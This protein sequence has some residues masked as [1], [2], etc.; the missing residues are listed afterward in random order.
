[1]RV[2]FSSTSGL[3]HVQPMLPLALAAQ[4]QGHEVLWVSAPDA[5]PRVAAA[6]LATAAAGIP[7]ADVLREY[8]RAHPSWRSRTGEALADHMFPALFGEIAAPA[9]LPDLLQ[10]AARF[11]PEVLVHEAAELAA[12]IV[13]AALGRP[14]VTHGFGLVVPPHRVAL[15]AA[16]AHSLWDAVGLAPSPYGGCYDHL[17]LDIYPPSLQPDD[18]SYIGRIQHLRPA[19]LTRLAG[20]RLP[21]QLAGAL[22]SGRPVIYLTFGTVFN[23][24]ETFRAAVAALARLREVMGVVTVGPTGEPAAFGPQPPH[25]HL[26]RYIPQ[27]DVLPHCAAVASH[28][29]SGTLLGAL[30]HAIPQLCLPQGAD[31]FRNAEA[32]CAA[33]AGICLIGD[34]ATTDRIEAALRQLLADPLPRRN[35]ERLAA[36]IAGMPSPEEAVRTL[37]QL[38]SCG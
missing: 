30:A 12:P 36:E 29:G 23:V 15:A 17:Y 34:E 35:A 28:G 13:G 3:G 19:S 4:E 10:V 8:H 25:V 38:A 37:E 33:G 21:P 26:A 6:G 7:I 2:L 9:L 32:C 14:H 24:N 20:D 31:Q 11:Q 27:S 18:L 16:A 5:C 22:R 1:M